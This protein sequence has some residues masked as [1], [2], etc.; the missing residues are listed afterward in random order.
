M[1][2]QPQHKEYFRGVRQ[3]LPRE[4]GP[5]EYQG[6]AGL[7]DGAGTFRGPARF[8]GK[9][10]ILSGGGVLLAMGVAFVA[11]T[12]PAVHDLRGIFPQLSHLW[13]IGGNRTEIVW[14]FVKAAAPLLLLVIALIVYLLWGLLRSE[15]EPSGRAPGP[16][17]ARVTGVSGDSR[18]A[19]VPQAPRPSP[20]GAGSGTS[21]HSG[22]AGRPGA[23]R[24]LPTEKK[25][26]VEERRKVLR[27]QRNA[28]RTS[29]AHDQ[30]SRIDAVP[31]KE[32][33]SGA[34][35]QVGTGVAAR[36]GSEEEV[37][38]YLSISLLGE[39]SV[40]VCNPETGR[41]M[42]V[43][44][45]RSPRRRE[46][47]AY[48]AWQRGKTVKRDKLLHDIFER[49]LPEDDERDDIERVSQNF[50]KH[51][52]L[53]RNDINSV[54]GQLGLPRLMVLEHAT[55]WW[56]AKY[57]KV[58]D[59][60]AIDAEYSIIERAVREGNLETPA[61]REACDRLIEAYRDRDFLQ[62]HV[63]DHE[64]EPWTQSWVRDPFT[65]YRDYFL[66]ALWYRAEIE[67]IS[68]ERLAAEGETLQAR[69]RAC[70]E[71]AASLY[72]RYALYAPKTRFDKKVYGREPGVRISQSERAL[73]R[74]IDM[75]SLTN[76]TQAVDTV[77]EEYKK[78]MRSVFPSGVAWKPSP[79]TVVVLEEARAQ[80]REHRFRGQI[81]P[82]EMSEAERDRE[83]SA[84]S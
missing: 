76:N 75:Y 19:P 18:Y 42:E 20:T 22:A 65:S 17:A 8:R 57:C 45:Q 78:L 12:L 63:Q 49:D 69:Q 79:E 81:Q 70:F 39:V 33:R 24:T 31:G 9:R 48:V 41:R 30:L 27:R 72:E 46:L 13:A 1:Q 15:Q 77:Y 62:K 55:D 44:M 71:R 25:R 83:A 21:S 38:V 64:F 35:N 4:S 58:V 36:G 54:A 84:S 53:L 2:Q 14:L 10:A 74:C 56:L 50:N 28:G 59:L 66:A 43:P 47:L 3:G 52:Q 67:R 60:D 26:Q 80:T 23:V 7:A 16:P 11:L 32:G 73:R 61:V 34:G 82:H 37:A 29:I 6:K 40:V 51:T 5:L 68:G